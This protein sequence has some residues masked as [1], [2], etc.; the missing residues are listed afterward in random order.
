MMQT[1]VVQSNADAFSLDRHWRDVFKEEAKTLHM[2]LHFHLPPA[3]LFCTEEGTIDN[4][5][6]MMDG[7]AGGTTGTPG[8]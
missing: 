3:I 6:S 4:L 7:A 8:T 1:N 2:L 5:G